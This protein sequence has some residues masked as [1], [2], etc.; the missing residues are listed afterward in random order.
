M[1]TQPAKPFQWSYSVLKNFETCRKRYY[2]Y[3]VIKDVRE[4]ETA[5]L[6]AGNDLHAAFDARLKGTA[7]PL[8]YGQHETLLAKF[9][10][11]PGTTYGEQ[12]LALTAE[13]QPAG[14]FDSDTWFRTVIDAAKVHDDTATVVDWKTGKP[15]PD[16]T[17]LQLMAATLFAQLPGLRRIKSALIFLAY[18]TTERADFT[19]D[20]QGDIW[21]KILPRVRAVEKA[22]A[23]NEYPPQ[24]SGLCLKYCAV[25]SCPYHGKGSR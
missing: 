9:L 15:S 7:L 1:S 24:P 3:N 14:Y 23:S 13:F 17:Q 18:K 2:H 12:K 16:L 6:K 21:N 10:A 8:G 22:R 5:Q 11:A 4:P 20:D 19:R 25:K